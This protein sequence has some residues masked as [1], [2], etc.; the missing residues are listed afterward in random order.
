[1]G[2]NHA[3]QAA[4]ALRD[5]GFLWLRS[6]YD[7]QQVNYIREICGEL[8]A[9]LSVA[10]F[11][12]FTDGDLKLGIDTI[13][14]NA[15][16]VRAVLFNKNRA[17]K[18]SLTWHQDRV[19]AVKEKHNVPGF[20]RW[21]RKSNIWHCEA[22]LRY[23]EKMIFV[24]IYLDDVRKDQGPTELAIA[25]HRFG[26]VY[27]AQVHE[28]VKKS[29]NHICRASKGDVLLANALILHRSNKAIVNHNRRILRIDFANFQLP[30]PLEWL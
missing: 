19:I 22:P 4:K 10:S 13:Y 5:Q 16:P 28:I 23:L 18:W 21:T 9:R 17:Q 11:D 6:A 30:N 26:K 2:L 25:S 20:E 14:P 15:F 7:N 29:E 24:Q 3:S 12:K 8:S 27:E 1:M